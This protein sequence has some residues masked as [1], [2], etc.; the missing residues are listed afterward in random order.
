MKKF[1]YR[2]SLRTKQCSF[3]NTNWKHALAHGGTLRNKSAG[4]GSRPLSTKCALHIVFKIHKARLRSRSLRSTQNFALTNQIIKKYAQYFRVKVE[5]LSIQNDHFHALIR[6][7]R[8]SHFQHFFRVVAGQIAQRFQKEGL[9]M[10]G[11][12]LA[13]MGTKSLWKFR[14]F[15]RVIKGWRAYKII[16]NYIQ[17]NEKEVLEEIRYQKQRLSGLSSGEWAIL[18]R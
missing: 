1:G 15:S 4:R 2:S 17:L 8:R 16:Q 13:L 11:T 3:L 12:P 18:W 7:T 10:T 14:P 6:T 9:L 5:Q